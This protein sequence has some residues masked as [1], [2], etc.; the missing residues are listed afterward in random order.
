MAEEPEVCL[1][2]DERLAAFHCLAASDM[3]KQCLNKDSLVFNIHRIPKLT[4]NGSR[5]IDIIVSAV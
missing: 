2:T 1:Q 5:S 4:L 3:V